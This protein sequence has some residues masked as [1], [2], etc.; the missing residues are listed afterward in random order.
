[1]QK[2]TTK[3]MILIAANKT[4]KFTI[5]ELSELIFDIFG[6][7][8]QLHILRPHV[9]AL[10]VREIVKKIG[11]IASSTGRKHLSVYKYKGEK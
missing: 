2:I 6:K 8:F 11:T 4:D 3:E 5:D 10:V 9:G 7:K 1:M